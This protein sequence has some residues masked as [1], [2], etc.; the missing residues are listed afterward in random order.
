MVVA[1]LVL[2]AM[3]TNVFGGCVVGVDANTATVCGGS[4]ASIVAMITTVCGGCC[5]VWS[6]VNSC[7]LFRTPHLA[8][9][10]STA[11]TRVNLYSH[12]PLKVNLYSH[13]PLKGQ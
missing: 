4:V 6:V 10:S 2:S 5:L 3:I 7:G 1:L 8:T 13:C 11:A 12:C 9:D